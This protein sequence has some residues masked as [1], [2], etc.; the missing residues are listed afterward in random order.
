MKKIFGALFV[1]SILGIV[2]SALL[3]KELF[4][5]AIALHTAI[6]SLAMYFLF[7]KNFTY[8]AKKLGIVDFDKKTIILYTI[9]GTLAIFAV[10]IVVGIILFLLGMSDQQKVY[11]IVKQLPIYLVVFAIV[12]APISEEIFFRGFI[13]ERFGISISAI[14]FALSHFAYGSITEI[15]A[16][17]FIGYTLAWVYK[18][19]KSILPCIFI[20][21]L[22]N[23]ISVVVMGGLK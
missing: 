5:H 1:L 16:A 4:L 3:F 21:F 18:S 2:V 17:F 20:H 8:T 14:V 10:A 15:I 22:F 19:S 12:F 11:D 13:A 23:L 9:G 7:E 6:F